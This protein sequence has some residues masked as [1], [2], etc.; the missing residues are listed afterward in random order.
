MRESQESDSP[1]WLPSDEEQSPGQRLFS[2]LMVRNV[3]DFCDLAEEK[4]ASGLGGSEKSCI[5]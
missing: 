5:K 1:M 3:M 2:F 4:A